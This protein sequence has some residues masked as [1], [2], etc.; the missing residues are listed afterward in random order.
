MK[1]C[2]ADGRIIDSIP[3]ERA[4]V[5]ETPQVFRRALLVAAYEKVLKDGALVTDEVSALQHLG[6]EVRVVPHALPNLKITFP[7]D[8]ALAESLLTTIA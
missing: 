3:R 8:L 7:G 1:R 4:W 2:D 6:H 5:M